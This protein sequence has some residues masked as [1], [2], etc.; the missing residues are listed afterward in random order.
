MKKFLLIVSFILLAGCNEQLSDVGEY[1]E[2][3][4][5]N[6]R[7]CI[8]SAY[9][10]GSNDQSNSTIPSRVMYPDFQ[11]LTK[12]PQE[13]WGDGEWW[14]HVDFLISRIRTE[15]PFSY[16]FQQTINVLRAY[17]VVGP[18]YDGLIHYTQPED[19]VADRSDV[20]VEKDETD[21]VLSYLS[22]T[23]KLTP[24]DVPQCLYSLRYKT[25]FISSSFNK[26]FL[27]HWKELRAGI[28]QLID[29]FECLTVEKVSVQSVTL[30]KQNLYIPNEYLKLAH[31]KFDENAVLLQAYY[32]GSKP[33]PG[34]PDKLWEQDLWWKNVSI[35]IN[36][37]EEW[38]DRKIL[39]A[40]MEWLEADTLVNQDYG[41]VHYTQSDKNK[42]W[43]ND[44]WIEDRDKGFFIQCSEKRNT[45]DKI[46]ICNHAFYYNKNKFDISFDRRLLP[47]W[48]TIKTN[49]LD[50]YESFK[51]HDSAQNYFIKIRQAQDIGES[52]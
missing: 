40:R 20:W 17:E 18:E 25:F 49:V 6:K 21:Q 12:S 47:N 32:P 44:V 43:K 14:R 19:E 24:S 22:C 1:H 42:S 8:P 28:T 16:S 48:K 35:L 41:L 30:G 4:I 52:K 46:Q 51:S 5:A 34:N 39:E 50:M 11:P 10:N 13:Y 38:P 29:S 45:N 15:K 2:I 37:L 31:T 33:V 9:V 7:L 3:A 27:P 26:K 23:D 36:T